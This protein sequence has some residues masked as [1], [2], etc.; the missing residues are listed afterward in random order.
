MSGIVWLGMVFA[1]TL[2]ALVME[3]PTFHFGS[4]EMSSSRSTENDSPA[5]RSRMS[6]NFTVVSPVVGVVDTDVGARLPLLS[7]AE[8]N[9]ATAWGLADAGR[10]LDMRSDRETLYALSVESV[11]VT[12]M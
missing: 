2:I 7:L 6:T 4:P 5:A 3:S 8:T 11:L 12:V 9:A 10:L 1:P